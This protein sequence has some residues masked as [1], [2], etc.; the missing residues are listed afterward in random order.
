M[1]QRGVAALFVT[2][3]PCFAM[4]LAVAVAHRNVLVEEQ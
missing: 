1:N 2:V 3:M 4:V